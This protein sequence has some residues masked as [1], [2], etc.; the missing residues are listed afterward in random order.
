AEAET[1]LSLVEDTQVAAILITHGHADHIGALGEIK[2]GTN[3]PVYINQLDAEGF[4]LDFDISLLDGQI[5]LIGDQQVRA[6]HTPGHTPGM[7]CLD[8]GDG[9][10]VVGDTIFVGGPGK[11]WSKKD[12]ATTMHTMQEI[13]FTWSDETIFYPGHRPSGVIGQERPAFEA[14]VARGWSRKLYG[15]VT[16]E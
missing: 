15:D 6:I 5:I 7:T 2:A 8:L 14:F 3:A 12:F 16:W 1:I 10:I 4:N 13:V 9:R 11:T